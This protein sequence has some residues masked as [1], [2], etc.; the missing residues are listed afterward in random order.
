[1][2]RTLRALLSATAAALV[3]ATVLV[4]LPAGPAQAQTYGSLPLK[5][6]S[7]ID[8]AQPATPNPDP[9]G[10]FLIGS[11]DEHTGR[12]Y[13]TFDLTLLQDQVLHRVSL[14]TNERTVNDCS[15]PAPIEVWRTNPVTATTTWQNPPKELELL[16]ERTYGSGVFC[17]GAHL[18]VDMIPAVQAA[19]ARGDKTLT[20]GVRIKAGSEADTTVGRT[21][22]PARMSYAANH[23]PKVSGLKLKYPDAGCGTLAKHPTAGSL[24]QAQATVTD[25]DPGD[26]PRVRYASWPVDHPDQRRESSSAAL[27]LSGLA[28]GT[29]VAWTARGEDNDDAGAWGKTCYF[30]V[31]QTAPA[32]TPIV[33]SKQ[34]PSPDFPGTGGPGV[35]GTFVFDAAGDADVVA[36]DWSGLNG[37]LLQRVKAGRPGGRGKLTITP[38]RS[39]P[40]GLQVAAV[41]RAGNRGPWATYRYQVRDSAPIASFEVAGV[42]L[43][44]H[45]TLTSRL[46]ETTAFGYAVDGGTEKRLPAVD[47]K[48]TDDLVF[49]STGTKTVVTRAYAGTKLLGAESTQVSVSDAPLIASD[50]FDWNK[51]PIEGKAGTFTFTPRTTGVKSYS[52]SFGGGVWTSIDADAQGTAVLTW[53]PTSGGYF[54]LYVFSVDAAGNRSLSSNRQFS[55]HALLPSVSVRAYGAHVG[56][57]IPVTAWSNRPDVTAIVYSFD[58]GPQRTIDGS[59]VEFD[60]V[61]TRAGDS[62]LKVWAKLAGGSLTPPVEEVVHLDSAPRIVSR[63]PFGP[64]AVMQRPVSFTFTAAQ[65]GATT[66][67]YAVDGGPQQTVPVG[68]PVTYDVPAGASYVSVEAVTLTADGTASDSSTFSVAVRNPGV[69]VSNPWAGGGGEVGVPGQ[70]GF[71]A[72]DLNEVTT[73]YLWH[74]D[75]EAVQEVE[76]DPWSWETPASYTP[77]RAGEHTLSVQREF[78]DGSRSPVTTVPFTIG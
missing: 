64:E 66:V 50:D 3:T 13:F 48:A 12:G 77:E 27:N 28:D 76:L 29:V 65:E 53:T 8:R 41:D 20:I 37:G 36:F 18:E 22:V 26:H 31:D 44:S 21:M 67:R 70:F 38:S 42:G 32:A 62:V 55:V 61:A 54:D 69:D 11:R 75:D 60:V 68:E 46:A 49:A 51:D 7:Y 39:G 71:S 45:I 74:V 23:A 24:I 73:K 34:Y 16:A 47:G 58:G 19:F 4:G 52:Y 57:P 78:T 35:A 40:G 14:Y 2:N 43:T 33:S 63:G 1:M 6:W 25:A 15:K 30:T 56:D 10:D 59:Y 9:S 17:P 72:W 5:A